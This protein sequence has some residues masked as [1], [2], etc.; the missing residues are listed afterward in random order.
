MKLFGTGAD[1]SWFVVALVCSRVKY[2]DVV[3]MPECCTGLSL[4]EIPYDKYY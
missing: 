3:I 4:A 1:P 2:Y